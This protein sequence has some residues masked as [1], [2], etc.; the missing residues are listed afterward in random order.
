MAADG[1]D[2][3]SECGSL[4]GSEWDLK[5][6][7]CGRECRVYQC[8]NCRSMFHKSCADRLKNIKVVGDCKIE[9]CE[10]KTITGEDKDF[11]IT[12]LKLKSEN[13]RLQ[14]ENRYL[15][16]L[17][18]E[19]KDKNYI[20][21]QNNE[22]WKDRAEKS[23][24]VFIS[25]KTGKQN[26]TVT[27]ECRGIQYERD[28]RQFERI[29][30]TETLRNGNDS[31]QL[32][33]QGTSKS[34]SV[35]GV[36]SSMQVERAA[37]PSKGYV[38]AV[39]GSKQSHDPA[40]S[41]WRS[42]GLAGEAEN[43]MGNEEAHRITTRQTS[44]LSTASDFNGEGYKLVQY[45]RRRKIPEKRLGTGEVT[46]EQIKSG[47]SGPEKKVWLY[48]YRARRVTTDKMIYDYLKEKPCLTNQEVCVRELPTEEKRLKCFVV[49]APWKCKDELYKPEFWPVGI[50]IKRF[51]FNKHRDFLVKEG[52]SF[53]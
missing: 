36:N 27:E 2:A 48:L 26:K 24:A 51:D 38:D 16:E 44:L 17:V 52:G 43:A 22:L 31:R 18:E 10:P 47:F 13:E 23:G 3:L 25:E 41:N 34:S 37:A 53:F 42:S 32:T 4:S 39:V 19:T 40:R 30:N 49:T 1:S 45:R 14:M 9:C 7:C 6:K 12:I 35:T 20:L 33:E 46:E 15:R 29:S 50:G 5:Y 8:I 11:E 21:K 28:R